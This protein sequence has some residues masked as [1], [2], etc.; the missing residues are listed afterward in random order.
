[1]AADQA[2]AAYRRQVA[3]IEGVLRATA[4]FKDGLMIAWID[5]KLTNREALEAALRK[6]NIDVTPAK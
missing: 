1:M 4:S 6:R 2:A 3:E 5:P